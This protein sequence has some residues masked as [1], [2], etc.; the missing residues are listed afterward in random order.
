MKKSQSPVKQSAALSLFGIK[1]PEP[2]P[3]KEWRELRAGLKLQSIVKSKRM[4]EV[5][6]TGH[7]EKR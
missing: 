7:L 1:Q 3:N 5:V 6:H 2:D 4:N